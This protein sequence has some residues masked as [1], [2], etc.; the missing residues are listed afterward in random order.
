MYLL[1]SQ[2][3]LMVSM[4]TEISPIF[5]MTILEL[6]EIIMAVAGSGRFF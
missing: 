1:I 6:T 4:V 5:G 2:D 3:R